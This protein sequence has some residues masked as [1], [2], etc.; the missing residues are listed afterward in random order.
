MYF[1]HS[2]WLYMS[3]ASARGVVSPCRPAKRK[4]PWQ[5]G[6]GGQLGGGHAS[7]RLTGNRIYRSESI[8]DRS[9]LLETSENGLADAEEVELGWTVFSGQGLNV[10]RQ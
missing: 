4:H 5:G 1:A 8:I 7:R 6:S 9:R 3:Y 10:L 2:V